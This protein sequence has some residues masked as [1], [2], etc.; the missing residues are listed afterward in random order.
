MET[1]PVWTTLSAQTDSLSEL[2]LYGRAQRRV[3]IF[4]GG[5]FTSDTELLCQ[6]SGFSHSLEA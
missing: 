6:Y 1:L 2:R 3:D 4:T 5:D